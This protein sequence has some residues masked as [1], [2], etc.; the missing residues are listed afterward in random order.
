MNEA[1][2]MVKIACQ[3]LAEKKAENVV[4][5]DIGG[6]SIIADYFV[7]TNGHSEAQ[8][9]A[10]IDE[11]TE[12]LHRAGFQCKQQEGTPGGDWV[13]LDYGDMI[14]HIFNPDSRAFYNLERIWGDAVRVTEAEIGA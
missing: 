2:E 8:I 14:V 4:T 10:M 3:A 6:L 1:K 9:G 7:I 11:V 12:K 5:L 13:L